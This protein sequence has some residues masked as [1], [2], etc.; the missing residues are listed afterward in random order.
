MPAICAFYG[1]SSAPRYDITAQH[2]AGPSAP[3]LAC[4]RALR[5]T[6]SVMLLG[7][8]ACFTSPARAE[9]GS[10]EPAGAV[11][12]APSS[13]DPAPS[14]VALSAP[15]DDGVSPSA[16]ETQ[17][18]SD[19]Y[20]GVRYRGLIIP[21]F[22]LDWF[23][24]GGQTVYVNGVGP[25]F[26]IRSGSA[27]YKLSAWVSF[28]D[29]DPTPIK[30]HQNEEE[31]WEIIESDIKS[32]YLTADFLWHQPITQGLDFSYGGGAGI[33]FI[34]GALY[35]TQAFLVDGGSPGN[36]EDY[37]P[38]QA[39]GAPNE[40]YCDDDN[41]HYPG[42]SEASWS[43]GG[44]KPALFPWLAAQVGLRYQPHPKLSTH[45]DLGLGMTGFM[46]GLGVDYGL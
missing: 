21:K 37:Q 15:P 43:N 28:Y 20:L 9:S 2:R 10:A 31:A 40:I 24:D 22:A 35:R 30:G 6:L 17:K 12:P 1:R 38:C 44:A 13:G 26:S 34:F 8:V 7:A 29:M 41:D 11:A 45:L 39:I 5:A 16:E 46:L 33:G 23:M 4:T 32:L 3:Q 42:F 27:E 25:E 36:P 19:Y 14:G 18:V